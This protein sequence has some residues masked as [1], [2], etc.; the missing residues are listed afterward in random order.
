V[1]RSSWKSNIAAVVNTESKD[2]HTIVCSWEQSGR[3]ILLT[4]QIHKPAGFNRQD[5]ET[6][7]AAPHL[8]D[9]A[10]ISGSAESDDILR[11]AD[12]LPEATTCFSC[13]VQR[14]LFLIQMVW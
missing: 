11:W 12:K 14:Y 1:T 7:L 6:S 13:Q 9:V 3:G 8:D 5:L 4:L 10:R 2:H